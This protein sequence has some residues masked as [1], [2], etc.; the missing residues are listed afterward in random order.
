[1]YRHTG[2][3]VRVRM[4]VAVATFQVARGDTGSIADEV[5]PHAQ[6]ILL[7]GLFFPV[8]IIPVQIAPGAVLAG[9]TVLPPET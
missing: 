6:G 2:S 4:R 3:Q 5:I 9:R 8:L 1:M 7:A